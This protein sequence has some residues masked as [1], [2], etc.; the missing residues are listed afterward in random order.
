MKATSLKGLKTGFLFLLFVV[1]FENAFSQNA[2]ITSVL[3]NSCN[4]SCGEGDNEVIFGNTGGGSLLAT[5]ANM[6][7]TYGS[8]PAPT[9]T[10]T[11]AFTNNAVTTAALNTAAG[12]A[13]F[14][15]AAGTTIPANQPFIIVK[16]TICNNALVW[17]LLCG[18]APIYIVYSTDATWSSGG[19]FGNGTGATRYFS[20]V[21]TNSLGTSSLQYNY[22]LPGAF[23]NDGAFANWSNTGGVANFYG[24][25]DCSVSLSN[26]ALPIELNGFTA[27]LNKAGKVELNWQTISETRID[28]F[29]IQHATEVLAF[30][31]IA[32]VPSEGNNSKGAD[33]SI[34]FEHPA[35]GVNYFSLN[36]YNS[37]MQREESKMISIA[38]QPK[39]IVFNTTNQTLHTTA[40]ATIQVVSLDGKLV[41][42]LNGSNTYDLSDLDGYFVLFSD[43]ES[44]RLKII[45]N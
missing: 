29:E 37:L 14:I 4:G 21:F 34:L 15:D 18:S 9:A 22:T 19:N 26:I 40:S 5:P 11:D 30:N 42:V 33:Y 27:H 23:G 43:E 24:D 7:V 10:Y 1:S 16:N 41:K 25:N 38:Y 17:S 12:C 13:L 44:N 39:T 28:H 3:I 45:V 32:T 35:I 20:S 31:K 2:Y 8:S 6:Q 36:I